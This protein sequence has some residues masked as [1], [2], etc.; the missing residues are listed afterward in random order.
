[1]HEDAIAGR[2]A[3]AGMVGDDADMLVPPGVFI[4]QLKASGDTGDRIARQVIQRCRRGSI[5]IDSPHFQI[6]Y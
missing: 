3:L 2:A 4:I 1:M 6:V 5:R